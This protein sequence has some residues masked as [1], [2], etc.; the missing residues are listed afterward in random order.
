MELC[1]SDL[2]CDAHAH[3]GNS[4]YLIVEKLGGME[5]LWKDFSISVVRARL[6]VH[7]YD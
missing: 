5:R 1:H 2:R 7:K 3:L 6:E 4:Y